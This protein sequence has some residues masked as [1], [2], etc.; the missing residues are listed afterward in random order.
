MMREITFLQA[1]NEAIAEEMTRDEKVFVMGE[2]VKLSAF[3]TTGGLAEK[4]G[5]ERIRNTPISEEGV[6]GAG[7][8]AAITGYRPII[9]VQIATFFWVAMDQICNQASK[10]RYMSGGQAKLP[11]TLR[12]VCGVIGSGAAQHSE[13]MYANFLNTP[14]LKIVAASNPYDCK[15][16][17]KSAIRDDNPVLLFEHLKL[18]GKKGMVPDEEYLVPLGEANVVREGK[19]VTMIVIAWTVDLALQAAEK[20][21]AEGVSVEVIDLRTI[22]P[23]DKERILKSVKKTGRLVI[24]DEAHKTGSVA[25][26]ISATVVEEV[27]DSLKAPIRRVCSLDVPI[28]FSPPMEAYVIP[29]VDKVQGAVREVMSAASVAR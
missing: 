25:S 19:D 7:I 15:G 9:E 4:F 27:F 18:G 29:D 17:L 20:M 13:T 8:G 5:V 24:V 11:I 22:V 2:D 16:L 6:V 10:L 1:I 3:G 12:T 14:G 21:A 28:P 26:E 23:W